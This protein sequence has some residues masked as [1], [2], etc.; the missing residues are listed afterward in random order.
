M[1]TVP[2]NLTTQEQ[3]SPTFGGHSTSLSFPVILNWDDFVLLGTFA[4]I[5]RDIV[6]CHKWEGL[7]LAFSG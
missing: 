3:K 7:L 6:G 1:K 4:N 2:P 5:W